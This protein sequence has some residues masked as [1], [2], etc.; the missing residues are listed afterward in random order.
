MEHKIGLALGG[1]GARGSYQIGVLKALHDEGILK[2]IL[3]ISGT[4]I[5]A[6]NTLMVM[7]NL[8]F[9]KM[10]ELWERIDN[11]EIYGQG[12][13]RYKLDKQGL[14]SLQELY[15]KLSKEISLSEI[16]ASKIQG[17]ATAAKIHKGSRIEQVLI[18]RMEKEVFHLN[19]Y[20]DPHRAVLASASIPVLF[21]S[22]DI[23]D[24]KY[25]DGGAKDNC[26]IEPLLNQGCDIII[27]VPIDGYFNSKKYEKENILLV[28]IES[29]RLFSFIPYDILDFKPDAVRNKV[30]YGYQMGKFMISKLKELKL[31]NEKNE[32]SRPDGF[33]LIAISRE[34]EKE[35][36]AEVNSWI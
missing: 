2:N 26:P 32:F 18:H 13:D 34:E 21:G 1:G 23:D 11:A 25:V 31:L 29:K 22:V 10:I 4:S 33:Q 7:S 9:E 30:E 15:D 6:I 17:Y 16:R 35:I 8:T 27:A 24:D 19:D 14:F 12:L 36:K 3:N 28:N 5:G 20:K